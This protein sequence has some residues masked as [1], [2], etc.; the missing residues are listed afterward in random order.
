[1]NWSHHFYRNCDIDHCK[2]AALY[3]ANKGYYVIRMGKT[4]SKQFD[5]G[6]T[7]V[8][9]YANHVSRS[10]F[11]DIYLTS[12]CVFF[13]STASGLDGV[14]QAFRKPLLQVN[15][16]P[17]KHQ[18]QY[19][20][21]CELF[22]IKKVFDKKNQRYVSI[23]EVDNTIGYEDDL[24]GMLD[25]LNWVVV[26]NSENEILEAVC[27]MGELIEEKNHSRES[28]TFHPLLK[29]QLTLSMIDGRDFLRSHPE[30]FYAKMAT[31]FWNENQTLLLE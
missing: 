4:V 29:T 5:V 16:A 3:L 22:I 10:D 19:W 12:R 1:M 18:L 21:P 25:R 14:A 26:E 6:H 8:I 23:K 27:E 15:I 31:Q 20:Y 11:A 2:Q 24:Q 13:I 28:N 9:D 17:F 30:K 7:H